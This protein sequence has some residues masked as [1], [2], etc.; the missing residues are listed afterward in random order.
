MLNFLQ[1]II[2]FFII[3]N[4]TCLLIMYLLIHYQYSPSNKHFAYPIISLNPMIFEPTLK[5]DFN[6]ALYTIITPDSRRR[7]NHF[8]PYSFPFFNLRILY[9]EGLSLTKYFSFNNSEVA[10]YLFLIKPL[11]QTV[12]FHRKCFSIM[13][14]IGYAILPSLIGHNSNMIG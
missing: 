2:I 14:Y 6:F 12:L 11:K 13:N 4:Y 1:Y 9:T 10:E 8:L 7:N 5:V 3:M